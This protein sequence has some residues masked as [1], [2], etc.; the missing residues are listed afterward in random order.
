M[1]NVFKTANTK[2]AQTM[3]PSGMTI[4]RWHNPFKTP[5]ERKLVAKYFEKVKLDGALDLEEALL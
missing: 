5:E 4:D 3:H 1:N 2:N